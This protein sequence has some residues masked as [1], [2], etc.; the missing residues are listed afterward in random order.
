MGAELFWIGGGI[1]LAGYFIGNGL[2]YF[3]TAQPN[4]IEAFLNDEEDN[5]ELLK[6]SDVHFFIGISKEDTKA[7]LKD[8]PEIPHLTIN[9]KVYYQKAQLRQWLMKAND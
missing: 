8:Y 3:Q 5:H 6:E 1:A 9:G 4:A 2:K 7:L